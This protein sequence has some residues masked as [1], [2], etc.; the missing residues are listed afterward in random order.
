MD[1]V[2]DGAGPQV[3]SFIKLG[4]LIHRSA[5]QIK[6]SQIVFFDLILSAHHDFNGRQRFFSDFDDELRNRVGS[7]HGQ[8]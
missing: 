7:C 5:A 2:H 4:P 8:P 6:L 1:Q 3:Y